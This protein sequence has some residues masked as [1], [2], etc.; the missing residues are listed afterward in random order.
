MEQKSLINHAFDVLNESQKPISFKELF[1]NASKRADLVLSEAAMKDKMASLYSQLTVDG[2]FVMV[3]NGMWDLINRYKFDEVH[4]KI[5]EELEDE[6]EYEDD[7]EE[8]E[9]IKK[10]LGYDEVDDEES[11]SDDDLDFDKPKN[12]NEDEF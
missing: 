9:F 1:F 2:R 6:S 5:D 10:E 7:A 4:P 3:G 11:D 12:D 8:K